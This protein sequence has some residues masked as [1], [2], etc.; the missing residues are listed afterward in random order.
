MSSKNQ[1]PD[2]LERL[3]FAKRHAEIAK[4]RLDSTLV[5]LQTRVKPANLANEAWDGVRDRSSSFADTAM[6]EAKKRPAVVGAAV[7]VLALLLARK[8]IGRALGRLFS[9]EDEV[10]R[11]RITTVIPTDQQQLDLGTPVVDLSSKGVTHGQEGQS[12]RHHDRLEQRIG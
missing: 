6:V 3:E 8:P 7:G 9:S 1:G 5:A 2:S 12:E 10:E 4:G 11:N